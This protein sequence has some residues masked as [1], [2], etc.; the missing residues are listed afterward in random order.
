MRTDSGITIGADCNFPGARGA[1]Y[2]DSS[3]KALHLIYNYLFLL[4]LF[5][6]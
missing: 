6:R 3:Y 4:V 5:V 1:P 2:L